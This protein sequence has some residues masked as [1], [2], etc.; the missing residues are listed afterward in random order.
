MVIYAV[1][2]EYIPT[3]SKVENSEC[4]LLAGYL[5]KRLKLGGALLHAKSWYAINRAI[6]FA[7][8]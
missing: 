4:I 3:S 2:E 8:Y 6:E 5:R 7:L 1:A